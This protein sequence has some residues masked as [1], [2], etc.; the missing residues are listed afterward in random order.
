VAVT[1]AKYG[2][3]LSGVLKEKNGDFPEPGM[4]D[5]LNGCYLDW[6]RVVFDLTS[7]T[8][9]KERATH[10]FAETD[11]ES[12]D[13]GA[14]DPGNISP[15]C[16][17]LPLRTAP[18]TMPA[19]PIIHRMSVHEL[20][21]QCAGGNDEPPPADLD[22][23]GKEFGTFIH[24]VIEHGYFDVNQHLNILCEKIASY[25]PEAI[26]MS[27][28]QW[29]DYITRLTAMDA[30]K[31]TRSLQQGQLISEHPVEGIL[32][33]S[34]GQTRLHVSGI[35]D[36]LYTVGGEW[37][38]RDYKTDTTTRRRHQ[39]EAQ[40]Q[41]YLHLARAL[42]HIPSLR[43][44]LVYLSR[45][46]VIPISYHPEFFSN[47]SLLNETGWSIPQLPASTIQLPE[48]LTH[49]A[50]NMLVICPTQFR[51]SQLKSELSRRR[52]LHPGMMFHTIS[53]LNQRYNS[54]PAPLSLIR[55]LLRSHLN[56]EFQGQSF[57]EYPGVLNALC[58]AFILAD[59]HGY[60]PGPA[61]ESHFTKIRDVLITRGIHPYLSESDFQWKGLTGKPVIADCWLPV[62]QK[63]RDFLR[64]A[65]LYAG[66]CTICEI[67]DQPESSSIRSES[68]HWYQPFDVDAEIGFI[69]AMIKTELDNGVG[70]DDMLVVLPTMEKLVPRLVP[71][72]QSEGIPILL[73]KGEPVLE[74][75][76]VQACLRLLDIYILP[77]PT[78][79]QLFTWFH[80]SVA[81]A[82]AGENA[83]QIRQGLLTLDILFRRSEKAQIPLDIHNFYDEVSG[84]VR[85]PAPI[86]DELNLAISYTIRCFEQWQ[87]STAPFFIRFATYIEQISEMYITPDDMDRQSLNAFITILNNLNH[88]VQTNYPHLP[89]PGYKIELTEALRHQDI[90]TRTQ[91]EGIPVVSVMESVNHVTEKVVFVPGLANGDFPATTPTG[92]LLPD[93]PNFHYQTNRKIFNS[94][95][96]QSGKI[97]LSCA[98]RGVDGEEQMHSLF[99]ENLKKQ[100]VIHPNRHPFEVTIRKRI[101]IDRPVS[102][103]MERQ[104][105]RHN[106][107]LENP[108]D[109]PYFGRINPMTRFS[110]NRYFSA[111]Q[112]TDLQNAPLVFLMKHVWKIRE[113]DPVTSVPMQL[114]NL[115]HSILDRFGKTHPDGW[116]LNRTDPGAACKLLA[117]I[118]REAVEKFDSINFELLYKLEPYVLG[119]DDT[120]GFRGLF[121]NLLEDDAQSMAN[122]QFISSEQGFG[123][124]ESSLSELILDHPELGKISFRGT[125]DRV[126]IHPEHKLI[127]GLDFKTGSITSNRLFDQFP[128]QLKLYYL[129]LKQAYP[130]HRIVMAYYKLK[131]LR[132]GEWGFA[133]PW[134][135]DAFN[136]DTSLP[137]R[138]RDK[139]L[140]FMSDT[141]LEDIR[142]DILSLFEPVVTGYF[143]ALSP[144]SKKLENAY[145][146]LSG[147]SRID[148][149]KYNLDNDESGEE[150]DE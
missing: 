141:V 143:S 134:L 146:Y 64:R 110:E 45:N 99:L 3:I 61:L 87:A 16:T 52:L 122:F 7:D 38:V 39:Y 17:T 84:H 69:A 51:I 139:V 71:I 41:I 1:R 33:A 2:V 82:L 138:E 144:R 57:Q 105:N 23:Y 19:A 115:I 10:P 100:K 75:P 4:I 86:P 12:Y 50:E 140:S 76:V 22:S 119:L 132:G 109:S 8:L 97:Y 31:T 68:L 55:I 118:C 114:G 91:I 26:P 43:G 13:P 112:L 63:D 88:F 95:L 53:S 94:W 113:T 29:T 18:K 60:S 24:W 96:A 131:K 5:N 147:P 136:H 44:E 30:I 74:R 135:G 90:P 21:E 27:E 83:D 85:L 34:G 133:R 102:P 127:L 62:F 48:P 15:G 150:T 36:A 137:I 56:D 126:D 67:P 106:V 117:A 78:W 54:P 108:T 9:K 11:I 14:I 47:L 80:H 120:G 129:V 149:I 72:F 32:L 37:V 49:P 142:A 77:S 89:E 6:V 93:T 107:I 46:E 101:S 20:S 28:E 103:A 116:S 121:K 123:Y 66:Q 35:I 145:Y 81:L 65:A 40:V 25:P 111:S 73:A 128:P 58:T 42:Y 70:Y 98:A 104:V 124:G 79:N 59:K 148:T 92:F 130:D 125:I